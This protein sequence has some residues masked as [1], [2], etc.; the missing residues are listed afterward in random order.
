MLTSTRCPEMM[1]RRDD[2]EM[3]ITTTHAP[4][5]GPASGQEPV[6]RALLGATAV[7]VGPAMDVNRAGGAGVAV[8]EVSPSAP[9]R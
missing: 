8:I 7:T 6:L 9:A 4:R 1:P 3:M 5:H 2:G